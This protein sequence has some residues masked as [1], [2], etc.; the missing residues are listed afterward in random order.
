MNNF[1]LIT[2][3][4]A[5]RN[6]GKFIF[7]CLESLSKL[8]YPKNLFSIIV[9]DGRSTDDTRTK[10]EEFRRQHPD[11]SIRLLENT[12]INAAFGRNLIVQNTQTDLI[13]FTD[14]DCIVDSQWLAVL[15][16]NIDKEKNTVCVGGPNLVISTDPPLAKIVTFIQ[17]TIFGSGGTPQAYEYQQQKEVSSLPNCNALYLKKAILNA[18]GYDP[19]FKVGQD[20]ELNYRIHDK[21]GKFFFI[22]QAIVYHH[23][24][25]TLLS[26]SKRM[27]LYGFGM[28]KMFQKHKRIIRWY[29]VFTPLILLFS[30]FAFLSTIFTIIFFYIWLACF[31]LYLVLC[32]YLTILTIQ[33]EKNKLAL[34][35]PVIYTS[36]IV[37][38]GI[39]FFY[40]MLTV[41]NKKFPF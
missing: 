23:R 10:T 15:T 34:L 2:I 39:G 20:G 32:F 27:F 12:G 9:A 29:A 13:A 22:P 21:G 11:L 26:F 33:K 19:Y 5:T 25:A 31:G 38:Y 40:G 24:R 4:I 18:G 3:G 35:A 41:K 7:E 14:G 6:E 36:Q 37:S 16:E 1:P 17:S 8:E 30:L 28:A